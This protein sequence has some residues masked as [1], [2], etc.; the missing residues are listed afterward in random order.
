[1]KNTSGIFL[2]SNNKIL[3]VHPT[4]GGKHWSIPKGLVELD[5]DS[6]LDAGIRELFEETSF[7][8]KQY[9]NI[10]PQYL[11]SIKYKTQCK[12]LGLVI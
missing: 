6:I 1:M 7:D 2:I 9:D 10:I 8:L 5:D 12:T 11:G 4:N 3:L